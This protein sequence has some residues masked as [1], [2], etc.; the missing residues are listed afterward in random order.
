MGD[1]EKD[2]FKAIN[3][4]N[5]TKVN[6][7][8]T[9]GAKINIRDEQGKTPLTLATQLNF[10]PA[11]KA[12]I[13]HENIIPSHSE[14]APNYKTAMAYAISEDDNGNKREIIDCL[15]SHHE[16]SDDDVGL[17]FLYYAKIG[18]VKKIT[19]CLQERA[20]DI[21]YNHRHFGTALHS[22]VANKKLEVVQ[23]LLSEREINVNC[24][25]DLH[26]TP[27]I[28]AIKS[29]NSDIF[30]LLLKREDLVLHVQSYLLG[31]PLTAAIYLK[32]YDFAK[33][34][35]AKENTFIDKLHPGAVLCAIRN[36]AIEILELLIKK[37]A[38]VNS[39]GEEGYEEP[40]PEI[41]KEKQTSAFFNPSGATV[42][43]LPLIV[44]L[45]VD[46]P[47]IVDLLLNSGA[48]KNKKSSKGITAADLMNKIVP[49]SSIPVA[50]KT[51]VTPF[52]SSPPTSASA[53]PPRFNAD[54]LKNYLEWLTMQESTTQKEALQKLNEAVAST[55]FEI[56]NTT[57][58]QIGSSLSHIMKAEKT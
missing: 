53:K 30:Y 13:E 24:L 35:L 9:K 50:E 3:S 18:D 41:W 55:G 54:D 28:L 16:I 46:Q 48:D 33:E 11:V 45:Q 12:L 17:A 42:F 6:D 4:K 36:G 15:F 38:N 39:T 7:C 37:G 26:E 51:K 52:Y 8:L 56:T 14:G 19:E 43:E 44:A 29:S 25:N 20:V 21:N 31:T 5:I 10:L 22:A 23:A 57:L 34:L 49:V 27:I 1:L 2:L 32:K 47:N 58:P 40:P